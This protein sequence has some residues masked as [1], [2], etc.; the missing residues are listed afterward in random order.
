MLSGKHRQ[1]TP[2]IISY[3]FAIP[4]PNYKDLLGFQ[5]LLYCSY[6]NLTSSAAP[7]WPLCMKIKKSTS[8]KK[9][10][11]RRNHINI[12]GNPFTAI[13]LRKSPEWDSFV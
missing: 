10:M 4:Y 2:L 12:T 3:P 6:N 1:R 13:K 7:L 8:Q 11:Q 5:W 9:K